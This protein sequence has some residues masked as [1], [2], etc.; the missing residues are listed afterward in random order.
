MSF[1]YTLMTHNGQAVEGQADFVKVPGKTA[2]LGVLENHSPSLV[3]LKPGTVQIK[4][5]DKVQIYFIPD[6]IA[7]VLTNSVSILTSDFE[8]ADLIDYEKAKQRRDENLSI[9]SSSASDEEKDAAK[10]SLAR[11]EERIYICE[12]L[13]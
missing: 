8:K 3:Q 9:L 6:G 1:H 2:E 12:N 13:R 11:A 7:H 5:D 10:A 4:S